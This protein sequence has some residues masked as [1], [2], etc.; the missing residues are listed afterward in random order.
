MV[1]WHFE[2]SLEW[3]NAVW[4]YLL[5]CH[6]AATRAA[7]AVAGVSP[8][9]TDSSEPASQVEPG[10]TLPSWDVEQTGTRRAHLSIGDRVTFTKTITD[11]D[12]RQFAAASGDTNPLH[13][14]DEF[15]EKTRFDDQIV[16]GT[17]V[18]G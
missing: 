12:V 3:G 11:E 1:S 8:T 10:D 7:F 17:L 15:A 13:L 4:A 18:R 14:D 6:L 2:R 9:E 16:H 5:E